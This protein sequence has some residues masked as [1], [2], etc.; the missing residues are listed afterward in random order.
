MPDRRAVAGFASSADMATPNA[1][2]AEVMAAI[3][4]TRIRASLN[5]YIPLATSVPME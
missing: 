1:E 2:R 3:L 4:K 5:L